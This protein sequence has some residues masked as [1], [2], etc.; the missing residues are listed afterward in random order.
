MDLDMAQLG[1]I[2]VDYCGFDLEG[3]HFIA[4]SPTDNAQEI[5][6]CMVFTLV[7]SQDAREIFSRMVRDGREEL[8]LRY[9]EDEDR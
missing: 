8:E 3:K 5:I 7:N 9:R 6:R 1:D 2:L 4:R